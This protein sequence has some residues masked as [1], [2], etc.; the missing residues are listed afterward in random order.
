MSVCFCDVPLGPGPLNQSPHL[1]E[2]VGRNQSPDPTKGSG[3]P[4]QCWR[5]VDPLLP[6]LLEKATSGPCALR[7]PNLVL[8]GLVEHTRHFSPSAEN[9]LPRS[10]RTTPSPPSPVWV[11]ECQSYFF[12]QLLSKTDP[13]DILSTSPAGTQCK[14]VSCFFPPVF[15]CFP[16]QDW[17]LDIFTFRRKCFLPVC[18][19]KSWEYA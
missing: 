17:L 13:G 7:Q 16:D 4:E 18:L 14:L 11:G 6:K 5:L 15:S 10:S 3:S 1:S 2:Q 8:E 19:K 9:S 12:F